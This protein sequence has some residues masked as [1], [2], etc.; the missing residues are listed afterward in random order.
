VVYALLGPGWCFTINGVSFIAV[1]SALLM[2]RLKPL[3]SRERTGTPFDDLKEG[4]RYVVS[5]PTIRVLIVVATMATVFGMSFVTLMPAWAVTILHGNST[6]NGFLQSA[7]GV[8]SLIGGLMIAS[9]ARNKIKGKVLT[10]G[11]LVFPVLLLVWSA[12]RWLP[13]SLLALLGVGWGLMLVFN[14]A[15]I[16]VQS[17]VS[18]QLRGRVMSIYS[19]GFFG[20]FPVGALLAGIVA[21]KIGAPSTVVLGAMVLLAFGGVLL[22]RMPQLRALE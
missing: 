14:M 20:M 12:M 2:M 17:V 7:R 8:G 5:H 15:N 4:L 22:L 16:L 1:I 3:T 9:L 18:D 11:S 13:L 21:E 6:T 19:L 10:L